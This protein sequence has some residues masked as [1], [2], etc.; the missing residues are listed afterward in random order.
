MYNRV[1][2]VKFSKKKKNRT[3]GHYIVTK[4][5]QCNVWAFIPT[6]N[7][8]F[9]RGR[10]LRFTRDKKVTNIESNFPGKKKKKVSK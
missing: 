10:A 9:K 7:R 4:H 1:Q 5:I 8:L 3:L 2:S 6:V